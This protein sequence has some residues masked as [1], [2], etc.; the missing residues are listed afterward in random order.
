MADIEHDRHQQE[1]TTQEAMV[2]VLVEKLA[3]Y[4]TTDTTQGRT[5][6]V[7][8]EFPDG[9]KAY[10]LKSRHEAITSRNIH[11]IVL[12]KVPGGIR[13]FKTTRPDE[14]VAIRDI[15]IR[16]RLNCEECE[17]PS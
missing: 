4:I 1:Q 7:D 12:E 15:C 2:A 11:R 14:R 8:H 16:N 3:T 9:T 5:V 17:S 6:V 13:T 10:K